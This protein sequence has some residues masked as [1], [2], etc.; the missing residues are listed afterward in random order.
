MDNIH[1][2]IVKEA[3]AAQVLEL[4]RLAGWWEMDDDPKH[5]QKVAEIIANT[6]RFVIVKSDDKIV[7]MGI[8]ISD[9]VSDAY[10]QDVTVHPAWRGKG[11]GKPSSALL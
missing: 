5:E 7:G 2:G 11:L 3:D 9:G 6:W 4:Y 8:A 1:I 10:I